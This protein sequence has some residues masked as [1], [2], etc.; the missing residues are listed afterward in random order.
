MGAACHHVLGTRVDHPLVRFTRAAP[1][2]GVS[3]RC[4]DWLSHSGNWSCAWVTGIFAANVIGRWVVARWEKLLEKIPLVRP[5]YSGVKQIME[6]VLSNRTESFKEVVLIEFPK[7]DCWT[8]GFIVSTPGR[9]A[10]AET[11]YDDVV[12]VFVPTA[13]NPTSGYVLMAPRSQLKRSRV[14]IED[15]FKFHVSLGVMSPKSLEAQSA[16]FQVQ[17]DSDRPAI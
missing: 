3:A 11:G 8:Y 1:A 5:I 4:A 13:P 7:K 9:A 12:T 14:S 6:T 15:A 16:V 2:A 10:A 17:K